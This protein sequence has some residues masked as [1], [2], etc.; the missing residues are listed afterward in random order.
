MCEILRMFLVFRGDFLE[1]F[2]EDYLGLN[3]P[4]KKNVSVEGKE[5]ITERIEYD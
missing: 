5:S 4:M 1:D 2:K 3:L